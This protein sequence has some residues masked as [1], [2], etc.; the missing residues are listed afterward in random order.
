MRNRPRRQPTA[1]RQDT[2]RGSG[3]HA[4]IASP[5]RHTGA[6]S[7]GR[8]PVRMGSGWGNLLLTPKFPLKQ[9]PRPHPVSP[10]PGQGKPLSLDVGPRAL[11]IDLSSQGPSTRLKLICT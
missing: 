11:G 9:Q 1:S 10:G 5:E 8:E 3:A 6:T 7:W 2:P 4:T